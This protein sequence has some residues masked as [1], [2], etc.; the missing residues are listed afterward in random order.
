MS[1]PAPTAPAQPEPEWVNL[2]DEQLLDRRICDLKLRIPG[3]ELESR[4]QTFYQE[5]DDRKI[6][7]KPV[8]YL[9]DEWFCPEGASTIAIPFYLAHPR[10]KKL[11]EHM[12]M[13]VEGGTEV[14]CLRLLRH[15][16]AHVMN[17]AYLLEQRPE[18]QKVFGSTSI[19]YSEYYRARPYSKRFVRHL[20]D[21]YAQ[22]H[23]EEDFAETFAIWLTPG[24]DWRQK[25]RGWK[26]LAKLEYV[27]RLMQELAGQPPQKISRAKMSEASRLRS[28]LKHYYLKRK[29]LYAQDFPDFFDA[30]LRRLFIDAARSVAP[31][32]AERTAERAAV[33]LRRNRKLILD[34]VSVW[35]GEPKFTINRLL[36]SLTQRCADLDLRLRDDAAQTSVQITAYLAT[37]AAHYRLTG[38]FKATPKSTLP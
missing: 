2:T 17:H 34:A 7:F 29:R 28:Q 20:E 23:P 32:S 5:L 22:S 36:K 37:L 16:M 15:E 6:A 33:F 10:L 9:G 3:T 19:D 25:Y 30:D 1:L 11:E 4:I 26:A 14:W 27:D 12:M 35:T 24:L 38:R 8:C 21:W 31:P 13:E 18:W